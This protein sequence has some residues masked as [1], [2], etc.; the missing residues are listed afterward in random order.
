[1]TGPHRAIAA[2]RVAVR[3]ELARIA[4]VEHEGIVLV[5]CS[6]G[7][8]SL[9][10]A[11]A[12]AFEAPRTG[13]SAGAVVVDHG[14]QEGSS[15]VADHSAG[16]CRGLGLDPVEVVTVHVASSRSGPEADARDARYRAFDDVAQRI[17]AVAVLLG[18]TRDDQAEQV[19]LGLA[20]GSGARS[21]SGMPARRGRYMRPFLCGPRAP[22]ARVLG[23]A[24]YTAREADLMAATGIDFK[25]QHFSF[26]DAACAIDGEPKTF[27][28]CL[29]QGAPY[30]ALW[31]STGR[32][33]WTMAQTGFTDVKLGNGDALGWRYTPSSE[34]NPSPPPPAKK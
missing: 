16:Q 33:P 15:A 10:L 2:T 7:A 30:W 22:P 1:M 25:T 26:G 18:H 29:P 13:L 34:T 9:A 24:P 11:A 14:L 23:S 20:R 5:A 19:L 12:V 21:L 6:G 4:Q 3:R 32:G 31:T 27:D 28:T 8:D 17:G